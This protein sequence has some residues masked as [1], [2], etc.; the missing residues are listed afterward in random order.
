MLGQ[1]HINIRSVTINKE[2]F[3]S[4]TINK[5]TCRATNFIDNKTNLKSPKAIDNTRDYPVYFKKAS[6]I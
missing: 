1:F 3:V 2:T 6:N 4:E 5:D